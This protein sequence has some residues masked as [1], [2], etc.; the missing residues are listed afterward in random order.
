MN[1]LAT[2][3][4]QITKSDEELAISGGLRRAP[5]VIFVILKYAKVSLQFADVSLQFME[6]ECSMSK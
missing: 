2:D 4:N 1:G 3:T 6:T 5:N